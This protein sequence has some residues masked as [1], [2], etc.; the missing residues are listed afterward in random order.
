[1][2]FRAALLLSSFAFVPRFAT[3]AVTSVTVKAKDI[4]GTGDIRYHHDDSVTT[5]TCETIIMIGVGTA[6]GVADYD[7]VSAEMV[8]DSSSIVVITDMAPGNF[9]KKDKQKKFAALANYLSANLSTVI[10]ICEN[11]PKNGIVVGGHSASGQS[12]LDSI[13]LL[14]FT[15]AGFMGMDPF[16]VSTSP[17]DAY[18][19]I[20]TIDWGFEKTTCF[21]NK[22]QA[23]KLAYQGGDPDARVFYQIQNPSKQITHCS[24]TDKGCGIA[25][26]IDE[27]QSKLVRIMV[28]ETSKKFVAAL[29]SG[30]F[31]KSSFEV[32]SP[33]DVNL[34]VNEDLADAVLRGQE[35]Q[36]VFAS[37]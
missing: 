10:P 16:I 8:M 22:N 31:E 35:P 30:I 15:A 34:S 11:L 3:A 6:M 5:A 1:M 27:A 9:I 13:P 36:L 33:V 25:C 7:K 23:A 2:L 18:V 20:P 12:A 4:G 37:A 19:E 14:D 28:G 17:P 32:T 21:V 24:F 29:E 26:G